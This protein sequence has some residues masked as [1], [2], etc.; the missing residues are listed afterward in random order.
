MYEICQTAN[1]RVVVSFYEFNNEPK[2]RPDGMTIDT[3]GNLYVASFKPNIL[4][5][6]P[7]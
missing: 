1:E 4:Q 6:N 5:I 2:F 7:R 3:N